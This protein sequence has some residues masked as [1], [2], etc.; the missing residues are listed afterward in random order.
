MKILTLLDVWFIP[1]VVPIVL[2]IFHAML[3]AWKYSS[4]DTS[5][6]TMGLN[7]AM[8][9]LLASVGYIRY[10]A[11]LASRRVELDGFLLQK[12]TRERVQY[13]QGIPELSADD[14]VPESPTS[15]DV[16]HSAWPP[17]DN[18]VWT[19]FKSI[20]F[21]KPKNQAV[22]HFWSRGVSS[23]FQVRSIGYKS[24][25]LKEPSDYSLYD[26]LGVDVV[27]ANKLI[28]RLDSSHA[29][30]KDFLN[31]LPGEGGF[32]APGE[33]YR[34]YQYPESHT[35]WDPSWG[36]PR[37]ITINIQL[38]Y[39]N[40]SL[41]AP[42]SADSDPGF[43]LISYH[44]ISPRL[45][46]L[47]SSGVRSISGVKL[48]QRLIADGKSAKESTAMKIIGMVTNMEEATFPEMIK[49][50]NGKPVLVTKSAQINTISG[51][52]GMEILDIEFDVRQWSIL[53][54]KTLHSMHQK[55][56]EVKCQV[57]L[58]IEGKTDEELPEQ[59]IACF[60]INYLNILEAMQI[61]F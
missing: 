10:R 29:C 3:A 45:A 24:S 52:D 7:G 22:Q 57:G 41:W 51:A 14:L 21:G 54:R 13:V 2:A 28:T 34:G 12:D 27:R 5:Y 33:W 60:G 49:G 38:P 50:Y 8:F 32:N 36:I 30:F 55:L 53:A 17:A 18:L 59:I 58:V 6:L 46:E 9:G 42:Q 43:S 1:P 48:L 4:T 23:M 25:K 39:S 56:Q 37:M 61:E 11:V 31:K 35:Q 20:L 15:G 16:G 40:P 44:V 47:L 26:C 19:P